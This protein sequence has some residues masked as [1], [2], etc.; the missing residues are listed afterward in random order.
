MSCLT[1]SSMGMPVIRPTL[2]VIRDMEPVRIASGV[3]ECQTSLRRTRARRI[4]EY[5]QSVANR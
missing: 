5:R 4:G 1:V 2:E 3:C